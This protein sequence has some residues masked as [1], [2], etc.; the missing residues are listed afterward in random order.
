MKLEDIVQQALVKPIEYLQA[1]PELCRE[2]QSRLQALGLLDTAGVDGLYGPVTRQAFEEFKQRTGEAEPDTLGP[3]SAKLLL[4]LKEFPASSD[5][6]SK[7]QAEYIYGNPIT[8]RQLADLNACLNR[9]A[10][11]TPPRTRHF[12]SQ[13]AEES[14]GLKWMEELASG[15]AYQGRKDLGDIYP[16]DGPKYKGAGVLQLTGRDNYQAFANYI[17]DPKVMEGAAYVSVVYPF[18]SAG[19]WW[20]S[21]DMNA[22]CDRL[23]RTYGDRVEAVEEITRRV[24]GGLN[25]LAQREA[26]YRKALEMFPD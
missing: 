4:E 12:L 15:E 1:D 7:A 2:V 14:G 26:Y 17:G 10:I 23:W 18:T 13:T 6:V 9:F 25:G 19:F 8:D 5:I 20:H 22:L 24:N 3:G 21:H 16:G 11:T